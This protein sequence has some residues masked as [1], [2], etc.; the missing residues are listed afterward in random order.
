MDLPPSLPAPLA[1]AHRWAHSQGWLRRFTLANR[2]L[3]AMAFLPTGLVKALGRRFTILPAESP[4]GFFFEA[5]YQTGPY[6]IFIGLVQ[7]VAAVLLLVPR[8]AALGALLFLPVGLSVFLITWGVGFGN[9]VYITAGMLL[10]AVYL[11]CWDGGRVWAASAA[12]LRRRT[13]EESLLAGAN[14]LEL[15][16][17][18]SGAACGM[19]LFLITRGFLPGSLMLP[20]LAAGGVAALLVVIGWVSQIAYPRSSPSSSRA[21]TDASR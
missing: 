16:G 5:M 14:G 7:V 12:V 20:L 2:I 18:T 8:T 17:W 9:T 13:A 15:A 19:G 6:W 11:V 3:L 1:S 21:W 10:S 4:V